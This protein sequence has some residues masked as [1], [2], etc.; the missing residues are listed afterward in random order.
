MV[1]VTRHGWSS[2]LDTGRMTS[3]QLSR[4]TE[5]L[6]DDMQCRHDGAAK[7]RRFKEVAS[8]VK[9]FGKVEIRKAPDSLR[10]AETRSFAEE[11]AEKR[12]REIEEARRHK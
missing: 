2:D 7:P 6:R 10:V 5:N 8:Y 11:L 12:I 3:D 4:M 9:G 1:K